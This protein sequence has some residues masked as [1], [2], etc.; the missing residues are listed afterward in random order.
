MGS[1]VSGWY[2]SKDIEM[3]CWGFRVLEIRVSVF[4]KLFLTL[5]R[6]FF[7]FTVFVFLQV[8]FQEE[9]QAYHEALSKATDRLG[10]FRVSDSKNQ[11]RT[12]RLI[13]MSGLSISA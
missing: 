8:L 9:R 7:K 11:A 13:Y 5:P 1:R 10:P 12:S 4:V 2:S 3:Y 6:S